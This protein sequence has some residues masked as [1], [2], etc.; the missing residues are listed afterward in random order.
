MERE[1]LD[2][3]TAAAIVSENKVL[4]HPASVDSIPSSANHEDHVSIVRQYV[5]KLDGDRELYQDLIKLAELI[6]SN[7]IVEAVEK[8]AGVLKCF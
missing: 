2:Q 3:Y 4:A 1:Y 8:A 7:K 5:R 6:D